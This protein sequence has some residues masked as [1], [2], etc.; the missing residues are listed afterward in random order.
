MFAKKIQIKIRWVQIY[1]SWIVLSASDGW[2]GTKTHCGNYNKAPTDVKEILGLVLYIKHHIPETHIANSIRVH[3][4]HRLTG[5]RL[6][7]HVAVGVIRHRRCAADRRHRV[8]SCGRSIP[9]RIGL[10]VFLRVVPLTL[11]WILP[12]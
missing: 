12:P 4:V 5:I 6:G 2:V 10:G 1:G 7:I 11:F 9:V 3:V 8:H